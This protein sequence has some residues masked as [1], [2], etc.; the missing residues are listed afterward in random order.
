VIESESIK[1]AASYPGEIAHELL[2]GRGLVEGILCQHGGE[3]A[4]RYGPIQAS[5]LTSAA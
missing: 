5:A 1:G 2:V 3:T 4:D